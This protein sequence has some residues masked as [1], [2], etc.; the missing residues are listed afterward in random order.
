L[1]PNRLSL[2]L[3]LTWYQ[4]Y[5][6]LKLYFLLSNGLFVS[7]YGANFFSL[8]FGSFSY[9][10]CESSV[11]FFSLYFETFPCCCYHA[12]F[13]C[14]CYRES[15]HHGAFNCKHYFLLT[16]RKLANIND[17]N[18]LFFLSLFFSTPSLLFSSPP[19]TNMSSHLFFFSL[20]SFLLINILYEFVFSFFFLASLTIKLR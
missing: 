16:T 18:I 13:P 15:C 19:R 4:S 3:F 20:V 9:C 12:T 14:C 8:C 5:Y 2:L 7:A 11:F 6:T 17:T 10:C 1:L